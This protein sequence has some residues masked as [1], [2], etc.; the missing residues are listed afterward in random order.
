MASGLPEFSSG[1][2][3]SDVAQIAIAGRPVDNGISVASM[4]ERAQR[5][6]MDRERHQQQMADNKLF[7]PLKEAKAKAD[8]ADANAHLD[9]VTATE[10]TR[11]R[12]ADVLPQARR[13]FDDILTLADPDAREAASFQW[14]G[15]YGQ[16]DNVAAIAP[17]WQ[18]KKGILGKMVQESMGI[19]TREAQTQAQKELISARGEVAEKVAGLRASTRGSTPEIIRL[20]DAMKAAEE[21][22]DE[23]TASFYKARIKRISNFAPQQ[24]FEVEKLIELKRAADAGGDTEASA[25]YADRL[26]KITQ[27]VTDPVKQAIAD[28]V[29]GTTAPTPGV[30][31]AKPAAQTA[32]AANPPAKMSDEEL[33]NFMFGTGKE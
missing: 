7:Q 12:I 3:P 25:V 17:E 14:M 5:L 22:G 8:L 16:L 15:K 18:G 9:A 33:S 27:Q 30:V 20:T 19:R 29:N 26:K 13:E 4:M 1:G 10:Q 23:E 11:G 31:P 24:K 32:P 2:S 28:K 6:R 21:D